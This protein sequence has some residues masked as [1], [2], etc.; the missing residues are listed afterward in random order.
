[1]PRFFLVAYYLK[2]LTAWITLTGSRIEKNKTASTSTVTE[3]LVK[4]WQKTKF[5]A[6]SGVG[7]LNLC[8]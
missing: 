8:L 5:S 6:Q 2:L 4:A 1:M 7:R 3:S